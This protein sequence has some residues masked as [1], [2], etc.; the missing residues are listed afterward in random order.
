MLPVNIPN[1]NVENLKLMADHLANRDTPAVVKMLV[2]PNY[3]K[4]PEMEPLPY[5]TNWEDSIAHAVGD[6][7][8]F[9][10]DYLFSPDWGNDIDCAVQRFNDVICGRNCTVDTR[11]VPLTVTAVV[12]RYD[13]YIAGLRIAGAIKRWS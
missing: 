2:S 5:Q 8:L 3:N 13:H 4:A 6:I 11:T 7:G 12:N 1:L 9:V 10:W